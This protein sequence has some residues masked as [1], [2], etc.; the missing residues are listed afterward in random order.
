MGFW[1]GLCE[2]Y[3]K[4]ENLLKSLF[5]LST[6]TISNNGDFIV[7]IIIDKNGGFIKAE[8]IE[9]RKDKE[10]PKYIVI[11]VTEKSSGRSSGIAPHPLFDQFDYLK[12]S[13][14]K[15]E[16]Y[17]A[18]LKKFAESSFA[19][20]AVKSI[21][22]YV[23]KKNVEKDLAN[24]NPKGKTNIVFNVEIP[25]KTLKIW[26]EDEL[27]EAWHNFYISK[28]EKLPLDYIT[29]T[30]QLNSIS[31]PKKIVNSLGNAKLISDND[32]SNFTFRGKFK[33]S[34]EA[35]S[36]GYESSQKAHQ[37]LR[38]LVNDR[39]FHCDTQVI[40]SYTIGSVEKL[41]ESLENSS[42]VFCAYVEKI[43]AKTEIEKY[44][45]TKAGTGFDYSEELS[46][47]LLGYNSS[48]VLM[49]HDRTAVVAS[50]AAGPGRLSVTFYRELAKEEYLEKIAD[51][52]S[53]CKWCFKILIDKQFYDIIETPNVDKI[54][55]A[56]YGKSR[57][58]QDNSYNKIKK[59][60]REQLIRCIF[61]G[62]TLPK[63]Y[64]LNAVLRVSNPLAITNNNGKFSQYDFEIMLSTTCALVKKFY[65]KEDYQMSIEHNRTDRD[66]LY[67]RLLGAADKLESRVL[68]ERKEE[69]SSNAI[70]FMNA[71]SRKPFKIWT[72]IHEKISIYF[73]KGGFALSEIQKI[74]DLFKPGDYENNSPLNG[75]YLLGFYHERAEIERLAKESRSSKNLDNNLNQEEAKDA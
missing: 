75:S 69:R 46:K 58:G 32:T 15:F 74:K 2:S 56:V 62:V 25:G 72:D 5:P 30:E 1:Q 48:K 54:I 6:T 28:K 70:R 11:P 14:K 47:A 68:R 43:E 8:T 36:I 41:P 39:G 38:Y 20:N 13:G 73:Q 55:E 3:E 42:S 61:D 10:K 24:L 45:K 21:Y 66:Y 7:V 27:F 71:F 67:G 52:H 40:L 17:I 12:G 9:K 50:D 64:I 29:G 63:N 57:G 51:W 19:T 34:S 37:F 49:N 35:F 23:S 60:A 16:E 4:N 44:I 53:A 33:N 65:I 22:E 31:H 26:E 59:Q 18:Q